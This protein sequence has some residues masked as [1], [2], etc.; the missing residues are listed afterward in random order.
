MPIYKGEA[1]LNLLQVK[2]TILII[3]P[4]ITGK[5]Y[6][7]WTLVRWLKQNNLGPLHLHD[8]DDKCESLV[9][10]CQKEGL[11]DHLL[12]Y[13]YIMPDKVTKEPARQPGNRDLWLSFEREFNIYH[14]NLDPRSG[15][16]K[17]SYKEAPG[18]IILDSLS[19]YDEMTLEYVVAVSGHD[20]G[21]Q[22]TDARNDFG[23]SIKKVQE[24]V[25]SLKSLPCITGWMAHESIMQDAQ[26]KVTIL[27][28]VTGK[29]F[30]SQLAKEF[31]IVLFS[32][33]E[34]K[35]DKVEYKWQTAPKDW[36]RSAGVTSRVGLPMFIDQDY[37]LVL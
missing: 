2:K 7:L 12:V 35:G 15:K 31:N 19:K 24:T 29:K 16:W 5:T 28:N 26:G 13:R 4:P 25:K 14:D 10:K 32:L 20:I 27:P 3:G 34:T 6:S 9:L 22:G 21:A 33:T 17:E 11:L 37:S 18:A 1:L 8:L 30:P 23:A 36:V